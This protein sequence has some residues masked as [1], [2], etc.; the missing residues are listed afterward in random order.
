VPL[1]GARGSAI[2]FRADDGHGNSIW[3]F[4]RRRG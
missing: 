4:V 3:R 1:T 2:A